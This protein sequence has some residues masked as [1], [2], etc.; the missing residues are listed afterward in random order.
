M[1]RNDANVFQVL[2]YL[3]LFLNPMRLVVIIPIL[4]MR[5]LS[6]KE[7]KQLFQGYTGLELELNPGLTPES[8]ISTNKL[9]DIMCS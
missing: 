6:L 8:T 7:I 2:S 9:Y 4:Q 3:V 5:R 1:N